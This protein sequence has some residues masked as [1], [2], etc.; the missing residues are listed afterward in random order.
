M[1]TT[2]ILTA[3]LLLSPAVLAQLPDV[4]PLQ[5]STPPADQP[6]GQEPPQPEATDPAPAAEPLSEDPDVLKQQARQALTAEPPDLQRALALLERALLFGADTETYQQLAS[7]YMNIYQRDRSLPPSRRERFY[8]KSLSTLNRAIVKDPQ[9]QTTRQMLLE[10]LWFKVSPYAPRSKPPRKRLLKEYISHAQRLLETSQ[11][12]DL[13][14]RQGLVKGLLAEQDPEVTPEDAIADLQRA[15]RLGADTP[16]YRLALAG[17]QQQ[18]GKID[19]AKATYEQTISDHPKLADAYIAYARFLR[20]QDLSEEARSALQ[21]G[22]EANPSSGELYLELADLLT[23]AGQEDQAVKVLRDGEKAS[24]YDVR[25]SIELAKQ[26]KEDDPN[27]AVEVLRKAMLRFRDNEE[28]LIEQDINVQGS[29]ILVS[30][31]LGDILMEIHDRVRDAEGR[32]KALQQVENIETILAAA[33]EN[34]PGRHKLAGLIAYARGNYQQALPHLQYYLQRTGLDIPV[35][36]KLINVYRAIG[37]PEYAEGLIDQVLRSPEHQE[38]L[39]FLLA[40]ARFRLEAGDYTSAMQYVKKAKAIEP[41][42][43]GAQ[44]LEEAI[45]KAAAEEL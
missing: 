33:D 10:A 34:S 28:M 3:L 40:K 37:A 38:D 14:C 15:A 8:D 24:P 23:T 13:L 11:D 7:L 29:M 44:N 30:F 32:Q 1:R 31:H 41:E 16:R 36:T 6:A 17:Y 21:R 18:V 39:F 19:D 20:E 22:I 43:Q 12:P 27:D 5:D 2:W 26:I 35:V 25:I 4:S 42:H 45:R 9:N